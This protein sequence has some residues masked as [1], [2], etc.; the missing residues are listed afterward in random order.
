MTPLD[1]RP[2]DINGSPRILQRI[3]A[4]ER[5]IDRRLEAIEERVQLLDERLSKHE[6]NHH[7]AVSV[8]KQGGMSALLASLLLAL[9]EILRRFAF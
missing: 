6:T 5:R 3:D 1:P 2:P 4:L 9:S 7:G 8:A